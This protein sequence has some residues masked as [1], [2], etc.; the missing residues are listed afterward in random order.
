MSAEIKLYDFQLDAIDKMI[1]NENKYKLGSVLAYEMGLGKTLTMAQLLLEKRKL[2]HPVEP[3]LVIA[4]LAVIIQW[5][6]EIQRLNNDIKVYIYHGPNRVRE[7]KECIS[8]QDIIVTTYYCL[9]TQELHIYNWNRVVID[10]AHVLRNG[11][12]SSFRKIPA[13]VIGAY[14]M[15]EI[16]RFR[17]CIT[18]TPYNNNIT[19]IISLMIFIG[20][21]DSEQPHPNEIKEF[22]SIFV[23]QKNKDMMKPI[24][25]NKIMIKRPENLEQYDDKFDT[26][27]Y[28]LGKLRRQ[29]NVIKIRELS[30]L[31]T[32]LTMRLR[33]LCDVMHIE[34]KEDENSKHEDEEFYSDEEYEYDHEII[35]V[36]KYRDYYDISIKIKTIVD[37]TLVDVHNVPF[38]R[39]LIFSAFLTTLEILKFNIEQKDHSITTLL[40]SGKQNKLQR[41]IIVDKFTNEKIITPMVLFITLGSG[42]VGLN[43]IPCCTVFM[44]DV[45]PNPFAQLQA[46]NRVHRITQ[47]NQVYVT[48]FCMEDMLEADLLIKQG[49][50]IADAKRN[51]LTVGLA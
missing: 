51:N 41:E 40:Y 12:K 46:I 19:D 5:K 4:P 26:F 36:D 1:N 20:H 22:I 10:E 8:S 50:K 38:K 14:K 28:V 9:I 37:K 21:T 17:Y 35:S 48:Q 45:S 29:K 11:V 3:D 25:T 33:L 49:S 15:K 42:S 7:L 27:V 30:H 24:I 16:S 18:G 39:I 44:V 23:L 2:E 34:D 32:K 31:L 6:T 43:L 47:K 13:T